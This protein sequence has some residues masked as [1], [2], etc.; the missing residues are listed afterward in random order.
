[1]LVMTS[2]ENHDETC[3]FFASNDYF[4]AKESN[5]MFFPQAML[6][7]L[8]LDGKILMNST[9]TIKL[10]P[11]GNGALF[12]SIKTRSDLREFIGTLEY[13]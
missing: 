7:A 10:S 8:G 2:R 12:D 5:F 6:P 4:G 13:L 3:E 11:N 9:S 1:M